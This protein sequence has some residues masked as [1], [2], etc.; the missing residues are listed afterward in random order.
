MK[1]Y[2]QKLKLGIGL[3]NRRVEVAFTLEDSAECSVT[4]NDAEASFVFNGKD[5]EFENASKLLGKTTH[6]IVELL[7]KKSIGEIKIN[8]LAPN[9]FSEDVPSE[10]SAII[11]I[12]EKMYSFR[13]VSPFKYFTF[14]KNKRDFKFLIRSRSDSVF[15]E[16]NFAFQEPRISTSSFLLAENFAGEIITNSDEKLLMLIGLYLIQLSLYEK[17]MD[18][19]G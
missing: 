19:L 1:F 7:T 2:R 13:N 4:V 16:Y 3:F 11:T 15:I 17:R 10:P 12:G 14:G 18:D 5:Y 6:R 8:S 9:R